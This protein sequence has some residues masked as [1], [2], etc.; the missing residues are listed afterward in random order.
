QQCYAYLTWKGFA[1]ACGISDPEKVAFVNAG[2]GGTASNFGFM[3]YQRDVV[4]RVKDDDGLPDVV[5]I[6]FSVNDYGDPTSH[7]CFESMVKQ[8]L[9][10]PNEPVVIIL[11][12]VFPNGFN[13]QGDL[14]R[15]G[16]TYD[17]MMVSIKDGPF[18][19]VGDKWT[20]SE[21]FF[22]QYHPTTLGH[23]VM[24]DCI[25]AAVTDAMALPE[26][27][28]D[29]DLDVKPAF[30]VSYMGL[31]TVYAH[32]DNS[33]ISLD[34]GGFGSDDSGSYR[35]LPLGRVCGVNFFHKKG[36]S[37]DPLTFTAS[38]R[39]LLIAYRATG[40]ASFGRA[41]VWIDGKRART[42]NG[43][44]GSWG[45]SV[46]DLIYTSRDAAEHTVQIRMA[47]G[48]EEKQFTVTCIGYTP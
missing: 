19:L 35:N 18:K 3:R 39:N 12:A 17:L 37:G 46:V 13:L 44:T 25:L 24:A 45:Q 30:G 32:G 15:I 34:A 28:Q 31:K 36:N 38:F 1:D 33:S 6:E 11:F 43:N 21:F 2:V 29:I 27:E 48:D 47:E 23:A 26:S 41:E 14:H 40:D 5:I 7:Q 8:I 22:D 20:S 16:D 9:M 4:D 10:Q 42:L